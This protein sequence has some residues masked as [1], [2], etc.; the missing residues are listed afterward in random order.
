LQEPDPEPSYFQA[1]TMVFCGQKEI[2][3]RLLKSA[4]ERNYCAYAALQ[5][6]PLLAKLRGTPEFT[7]LLSAAKECQQKFLA[8]RN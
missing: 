4:I 2:G 6:D 7:Q 3:A 1:T 8:A 5:S